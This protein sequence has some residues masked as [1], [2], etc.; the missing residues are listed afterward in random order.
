MKRV[1]PFLFVVALTGGCKEQKEQGHQSVTNDSGITEG[2]PSGNDGGSA[3][4][5][6]RTD[7]VIADKVLILMADSAD[8]TNERFEILNADLTIFTTIVG[9]SNNEP[10]GE[11]LSGNI[12]TYYPDYY[13]IH[14]EGTSFDDSL[15]AIVVSDNIKF[16]RKGRFMELI[17][18][19]EYILRYFCMTDATNPVREE[20]SDNAAII[21]VIDYKDLSFRCLEVRN[22]WVRVS[23]N[24]DCEGCPPNSTV[25]GWIRWKRDGRRIIKQYYTC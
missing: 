9:D 3:K 20:P 24:T 4:I 11:G 2:S 12:L 15:Y 1:L 6:L 21:N 17:N 13:L 10:S 16:I 18:W 22:D 5:S 14:F 25:Q 19:H 7:N 23:C 8:R